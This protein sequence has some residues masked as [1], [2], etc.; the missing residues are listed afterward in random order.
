MTLDASM[1]KAPN[2]GRYRIQPRG[3]NDVRGGKLTEREHERNAP[4]RRKSAD[5]KREPNPKSTAGRPVSIDRGGFEVFVRNRAQ[6]RPEHEKRVRQSAY[7]I[8][9]DDDSAGIVD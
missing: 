3:Q 4:R 1:E 6:G 8:S 9:H 5:G 2:Q 7:G